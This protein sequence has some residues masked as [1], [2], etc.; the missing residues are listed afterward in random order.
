MAEMTRYMLQRALD[1]AAQED[2]ELARA[3]PAE[4]DQVDELFNQI[5]RNLVT[6]ITEN[7]SQIEQVNRLEWAAH[8]LER[9]ADRVINICEWVVYATTAEYIEMDTEVESPP[10]QR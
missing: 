5:Y 7:P 6:Y 3:I 8:N 9:A 4:D 10:Q 2:T 1:A